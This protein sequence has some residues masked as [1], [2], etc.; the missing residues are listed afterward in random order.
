M[1][2]KIGISGKRC[3]KTACGKGSISQ[4]A[5]TSNPAR[6]AAIENPP[7]PLNKSSIFISEREVVGIGFDVAAFFGGF[8]II[9]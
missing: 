6:W 8:F 9:I 4:C 3:L 1:S 7:I 2:S 5:T